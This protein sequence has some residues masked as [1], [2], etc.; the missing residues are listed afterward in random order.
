MKLNSDTLA[1]LENANDFYVLCTNMQGRYSHVSK[2]FQDRFGTLYGDLLGQEYQITLHPDD[3]GICEQA[4]HQCLHNPGQWVPCT[5]RKHNGDNG[6]VTTDWEFIG[7]FDENGKPEG[8]LCIGY[9]VT[10]MKLDIEKKDG[11]LDKIAVS[12][13]HGVRRP[14]ANILG[15]IELLKQ[16]DFSVQAQEIIDL[17]HSNSIELDNEIKN[18]VNTI[19]GIE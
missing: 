9:D 1:F 12:Q 6:Y 14:L 15:L 19:R 11:L 4:G 7:N 17:L 5:V 8:V 3:I 10:K 16:Y 2:T 13:S 18:T